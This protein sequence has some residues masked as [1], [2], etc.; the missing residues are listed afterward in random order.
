[1][2]TL[3][4]TRSHAAASALEKSIASVFACTLHLN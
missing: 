2:P 4:L 3:A 1:M